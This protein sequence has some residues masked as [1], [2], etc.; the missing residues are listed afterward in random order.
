MRKNALCF[1]MPSKTTHRTG[2]RGVVP[3]LSQRHVGEAVNSRASAAL[4]RG[5]DQAR[6]DRRQAQAHDLDFVPRE[7]SSD[8]QS[9]SSEGSSAVSP[10]RGSR[11]IDLEVSQASAPSAGSRGRDQNISES[12]SS[13]MAPSPARSTISLS[14]TSSWGRPCP[15]HGCPP[16][17]CRRPAKY[18]AGTCDPLGLARHVVKPH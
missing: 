18:A 7:S 2:G 16:P 17:P 5:C 14:S 1:A 10:S 4:P 9:S 15:P 12:S 8:S 11:C 13:P 3:S 6:R